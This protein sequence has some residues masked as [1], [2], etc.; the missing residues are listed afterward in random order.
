[1]AGLCYCGCGEAPRVAT[2]TSAVHGVVRG[3]HLRSIAA[4]RHRIPLPDQFVVDVETG[5]WNWVG[6]HV[7]G[8]G[9]RRV[10]GKQVH[11]F[12][13][14]Y[15][16][17]H[18]AIASG[19]QLDHLCRNTYCVNP[20]HLEP[21]TPAENVRRRSTTKLTHE[22]V[23]EM[24][25]LRAAGW[26]QKRLAARFGV[27]QQAVSKVCRGER[28]GQGVDQMDAPGSIGTDFEGCV[29]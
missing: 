11:V 1:M 18:G 2:R 25:A 24:R 26:Q 4:H 6:A 20:A 19:L 5:C 8:Y 14:L 12:V 17:L 15:E 7:K 13:W 9:V 22:T 27:S 23:R 28:W 3:R 21:V 29:V 10:N 16:A